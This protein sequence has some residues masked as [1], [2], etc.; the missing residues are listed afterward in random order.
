MT[1]RQRSKVPLQQ[2]F[3]EC[4]F[5]KWSVLLALAMQLLKLVMMCFLAGYV[6]AGSK[7]DRGPPPDRE[8]PPRVNGTYS[9]TKFC[10]FNLLQSFISLVDLC[11]LPVVVGPCRAAF[12]RWFYNSTS[13]RCESFTYG[14]CKGNANRFESKE[15]CESA[16]QC[17]KCN[18]S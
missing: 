13:Q 1:S 6:S 3:N 15:L 11:S 9:S 8:P 16:C 2:L 10:K 12:P 5:L 18:Y 4:W 14:G 17:G 7:N